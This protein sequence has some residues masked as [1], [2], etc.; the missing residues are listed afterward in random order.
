MFSPFYSAILTLWRQLHAIALGGRLAD[1]MP[2]PP[3]L[4][5]EIRVRFP[6]V[7]ALVT[8]GQS[9][10]TSDISGNEAVIAQLLAQ[11]DHF[12]TLARRFG[13]L[14]VISAATTAPWTRYNSIRAQITRDDPEMG[15]MLPTAPSTPE[16]L[17]GGLLVALLV[18][19]GLLLASQKG[20]L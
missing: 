10:P 18:G 5:L 19:G 1:G 8:R 13:L 3:A 11:Q 4:A 17:G 2:L 20:L 12:T 9:L 7:L 6:I 16:L 15:A 14:S